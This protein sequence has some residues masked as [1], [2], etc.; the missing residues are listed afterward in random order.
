MDVKLGLEEVPIGL[1]N[2][3][4]IHLHPNLPLTL[5]KICRCNIGDMVA[6][7]VLF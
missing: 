3:V 1:K 6:E 4:D 7:K 2:Y 5:K